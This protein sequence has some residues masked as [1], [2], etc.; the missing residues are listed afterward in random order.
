M[1]VTPRLKSRW[2][3]RGVPV[4]VGAGAKNDWERSTPIDHGSLPSPPSNAWKGEAISDAGSK[5]RERGHAPETA[6]DAEIDID[7]LMQWSV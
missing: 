3:G 6:V 5:Q 2:Y 7:S 4:L 1:S